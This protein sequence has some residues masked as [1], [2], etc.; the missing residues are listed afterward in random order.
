MLTR[1]VIALTLGGM[2]FLGSLSA[3][4]E[5]AGRNWWSLQPLKDSVSVPEVLDPVRKDW[6]RNEIDHFILRKLTEQQLAPSPPA[7]PRVL[8]RRLYI[9]LLGLP[10]EPAQV[11]AFLKDSSDEAYVK[12]VDDL[13]ASPHY[14]ERW[15]RHWLDVVRYGE[16][17]G[18]E[19]NRPR[20]EAW[21][22]RDWVIKAFN[23][24]LPYDEFARLQIAGDLAPGGLHGTSATGFLVAGVHNTVV[25][26]SQEMKLLARQDELEEIA[27][28][29]GQTFLGLSVNCARCHD[30]KFDP[31]STEEY[32]RFISAIDG[33]QHGGREVQVEDHSKKV[34][35]LTKRIEELSKAIAERDSK[36]RAAI[37]EQREKN[38]EKEATPKS[39]PKAF[40]VWSFEKG[41]DDD[42]G[43]FKGQSVGQPKIEN[44]ALVVDGKSFVKT[45]ILNKEFGEKTLAAWVQLDGGDQRGGGVVTLAANGGGFDSIVYGEKDPKRWLAGSEGFK[46]TQSFGGEDESE[47][48]GQPVFVAITYGADGTITGFRNGQPYGKPYRKDL[49]VFKADESHLLF[50][51]RHEPAGGTQFL[52]GRIDEVRIF[53]RALSHQEVAALAGVE[54][55]FVSDEELIAILSPAERELR[56]KERKELHESQ[57]QRQRLQGGR[58]V[59]LYAV[60]SGG[61]GVMKVHV[62]GSVKEFGDEVAPGA[63]SAVSGSSADFGIAK[64]APDRSRRLKMAE[65]VASKDN[66]L[67]ARVMVN[68]IWH[69]HFGQ[70]MVKTPSDLGFNGGTPSH[71]DLLEWLSIRFK[72]G[73]YRLK[74]L[75]RDI[76]LSATYRQSS[77]LRASSFRKDADNRLLWR[78]SPRRVEAE[79]LRD[80]ILVSAGVLDRRQGGPGF[81]DHTMKEEGTAFYF[82][83]DKEDSSFNRRTVYRFNPRGD[84]SALLDTFDCPDPSAAAP[85]RGITTTPLQALS[86]MNNAFVLRMAGHFAKRLEREAGKDP[87]AQ[88]H[89]AWQ[90]AVGRPPDAKE[91]EISLQVIEKHGLEVLCRAIWNTNE[92]VYIE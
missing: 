59:K 79:V 70:G 91:E 69:Y 7:D 73:G 34:A 71:P 90:A 38:P 40:A 14:G 2:P 21:Y 33:V 27:G 43:R 61:P 56:E 6:A 81:K 17:D 24:D 22:Y 25:G 75:H 26:S 9:D 83:I 36:A 41:F 67:L 65:W 84:R 35:E 87:K 82:P 1:F 16:S 10:P 62:R 32:Y 20:N 55:N 45:T 88:T 11:N 39:L 4:E 5:R 46:R 47:A 72:K 51:L 76:V 58:K 48:T 78:Y 23:E 86:L 53:D 3:E 12:L 28:A 42:S 77:R 57:E 30:H 19:R 92:F 63:L 52:R 15:A 85:A 37:R 13:L 8:V 66:P 68:R 29:I 80:A 50:G 44:G 18:F 31:I 89:L 64:N 49:R 74:P 54:T 60:R